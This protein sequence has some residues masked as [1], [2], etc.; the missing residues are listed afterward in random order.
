MSD[1]A[2]L[3]LPPGILGRACRID[4]GIPGMVTG[5]LE[6]ISGGLE[7]EVAWWDGRQRRCEWLNPAE[8]ALE[9]EDGPRK[10][11]FDARDVA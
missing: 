9:P 6:R 5:V 3:R 1:L 11:G 10:L 7:I 8:V 2:N 4:D